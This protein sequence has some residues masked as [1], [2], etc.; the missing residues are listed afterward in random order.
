LYAD[1]EVVLCAGAL[2]SPHLLQLSGVGDAD[3]LRGAGIRP[4]HALPGVGANIQDHLGVGLTYLCDEPV[5]RIG[6][7]IPISTTCTGQ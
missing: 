2:Q 5:T 1:R 3:K 4:V 6:G 7:M